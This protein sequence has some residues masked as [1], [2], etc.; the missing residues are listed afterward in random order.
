MPDETTTD[1]NQLIQAG[2]AALSAAL[3][4]AKTLR[5]LHEVGAGRGDYSRDRHQWLDNLTVDDIVRDI[6]ELRKAGKI[7]P[8]TS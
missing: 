4:P 8:T 7:P 6:A 3:G 5:F 2:V 1:D